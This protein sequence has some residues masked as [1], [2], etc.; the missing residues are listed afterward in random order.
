MKPTKPRV[1]PELT[2]RHAASSAFPNPFLAAPD[3]ALLMEKGKRA[4]RLEERR[5]RGK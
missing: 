1:R 2:I 5:I 3:L 4:K